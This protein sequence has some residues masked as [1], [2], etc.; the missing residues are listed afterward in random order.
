[1]TLSAGLLQQRFHRAQHRG[2]TAHIELHLIHFGAG[3][4]ADATGIKSNAFA[5]GAYAARRFIG[6]ALVFHDDNFA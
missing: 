1:M 4:E 3:F 2:R 5:L 6:A